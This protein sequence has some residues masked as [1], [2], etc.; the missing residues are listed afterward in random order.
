M[1]RVLDSQVNLRA[2]AGPAW[3]T[4]GSS[5]LFAGILFAGMATVT[6]RAHAT[7]LDTLIAT[8]GTVTQGNLV[9]SSFTANILGGALTAANV[10]VAP[11]VTAGGASG[12]RFTGVPAG[13]FSQS[14]TGGGGGARE[15]IVDVGFTVTVNGTSFRIHGVQQALD[16]AAAAHNNGKLNSQTTIPP[17]GTPVASLFSCI[18]G[19]GVPTGQTCASPVNSTILNTDAS[20]LIVD[21]QIQIIVG[22]KGGATI[23]DASTGF[24]DVTFTQAASPNGGPAPTELVPVVVKLGGVGYSTELAFANTSTD[25]LDLRLTFTSALGAPGAPPAATVPL[26]LAA[27]EQ[28]AV[29]DVIPWLHGAGVPTS[30]EDVGT[31]RIEGAAPGQ[32][33]A[34]RVQARTTSPSGI[35]HAGVGYGALASSDFATATA[36]VYG[37]RQ[38]VSD[39]SNLAV[40]NASAQG[41]A[42]FR[43]TLFSGDPADP[44][45]VVLSP[46]LTLGAGEWTQLNRV[47]SL[48]GM[49]DGWAKVEIV[50]GGAPFVAYGVVNDAVTNDGSYLGMS[51]RPPADAVLVVPAVV[52]TSTFATE[53]TL[54]NPGG[55]PTVATVSFHDSLSGAGST[56][57]MDIPLAAHEQRSIPDFVDFL[58]S[59]AAGIPARGGSLAGAAT[60]TFAAAGVPA[61]GWAG[62]RVTAPSPDGGRFGVAFPGLPVSG[63]ALSEA[64]ITGLR[65]DAQTRSNLGLVNVG[66]LGGTITVRYDVYD[67][68]SAKKVGGSAP[69]T[70]PPGG[71]VQVNSVLA[72]F[73]VSNGWIQV[74]KVS[75]NDGF[76][77]YGVVNDGGSGGPGTNDGSYVAMSG[78]R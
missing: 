51:T 11:I 23:G 53:L 44:R 72:E 68:R 26:H 17:S 65:Q 63:A 62:A 50:S 18:E 24:F 73:G 41:A 7:S 77:A 12:L 21:R 71:W 19:A 54:A 25:A 60:V 42:T 36:W 13:S 74:V 40:V 4:S 75:G 28:F 57:A 61:A 14:T 67:G 78:A 35:G 31:L 32:T 15:I 76:I 49:A 58:R 9:F 6:P 33:A 69:V 56:A 39:R 64:F 1:E 55:T 5:L 59:R 3:T 8:N 45:Q 30:P 43:V 52:E 37:L 70:I 22:Q 34:V 38:S 2:A 46:D 66:D 27:G 47:L 48:A 20:S 10:D 29:A 16:P